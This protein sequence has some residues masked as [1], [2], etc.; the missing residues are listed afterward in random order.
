MR[1][2]KILSSEFYEFKLL[3]HVEDSPRLSNRKAADILG[4]SL[5]LA[6]DVLTRMVTKGY[7][8]VKKHHARRWDYFLTPTGISEKARLTYD[9]IDFSMSFYREARR[10]SAEL[11][12]DLAEQDKRRVSFLG[13]GDLA[14]ITYLGVKEWDLS[15]QHV[16]DQQPAGKR[17]MQ[18][19]I[20]PL[21]QLPKDDADILIV[22]LYDSAMPLRNNYL[23]KGLA[24]LPHMRWI[25]N[26]PAEIAQDPAPPGGG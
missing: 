16:Y 2:N 21:A 26:C 15:L 8:H 22:C 5:K 11:C 1:K 24:P 9:F 10:L 18:R 6:H 3:K 13:S 7:F 14:E 20:V 19:D 25:F 12:R 17:F 23:P 4:V